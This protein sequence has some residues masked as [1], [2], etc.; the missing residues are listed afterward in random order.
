M[1]PE[2]GDLKEGRSGSFVFVNIL[3]LF[4]WIKLVSLYRMDFL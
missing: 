4:V 1:E 2:K 3:F